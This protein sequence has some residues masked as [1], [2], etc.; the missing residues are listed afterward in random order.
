MSNNTPIDWEEAILRAIDPFGF[1]SFEQMMETYSHIQGLPESWQKDILG[2]AAELMA[3]SR[4]QAA[5]AKLYTEEDIKKA[6]DAGRYKRIKEEKMSFNGHINRKKT[7]LW[8]N[9]SEY[10][11]SLVKPL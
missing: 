3:T 2:K 8:S 5:A 11:K 10:I 1:R 4:E 6:F 9:S 7:Y